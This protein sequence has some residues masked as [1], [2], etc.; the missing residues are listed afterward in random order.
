M[1][2]TRRDFLAAT[3][4]VAATTVVGARRRARAADTIKIGFT[5]ALTGPFNEF[6]EGYKRGIELAI[7]KINKAGGVL[8]K[9]IEIGMLLDD[10][11]IPDRSVQN[12]RRIL[13]NKEI[14]GLFC[15]SGSGPTLAVIDMITADGRPAMNPQAQT[16]TVIYPGGPGSKPRPN[17][18]T[19]SIQ[20]DIEANF[21]AGILAKKF[22]RI[23][24]LNESTG[25]GKTG[26]DLVQAGIK[27]LNKDAVVTHESYNQKDQ[28]MTAQLVRVQRARSEALMV[29]GLGADMAVIRKN[30]VRMNMN[31]PLY[32][33]AGGFSPPYVE[34]AGDLAIGTKGSQFRKIATKPPAPE[35]AAFL[36]AYKAKFGTDRLWGS[37]PSVPSPSMGGTVA[38]GY[39]GM[40]VMADAWRRAGSTDPAA[41][42]K[43]MDATKG[44]VGVNCTYEFTPMKH[45]AIEVGDL[46]T[47]EY[48]KVD[49]RL[50][51]VQTAL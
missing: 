36:D 1:R 49:G 7:D 22:K 37:D 9:Q 43:A 17:V 35:V 38:S 25:Y 46:T 13:D 28:D 34:G 16:P 4:A 42:V 40:L 51:L 47:Y 24:L 27:R 8:G 20:N 44:F 30:M 26:G 45:H 2:F 41:T 23:G 14:V 39:D 19:F 6:G 21:M 18:Y 33:S 50:T 11:L 31:L 12:M 32:V 10:Q 5:T 48:E 3:G 29:V 15:P